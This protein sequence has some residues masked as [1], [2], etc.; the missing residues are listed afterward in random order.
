MGQTAKP[1]RPAA[2]HRGGIR[3]NESF[4]A[5]LECLTDERIIA[6]SKAVWK[7]GPPRRR[8]VSD[9]LRALPRR[10]PPSALGPFRVPFVKP[11]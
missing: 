5:V 11:P 6:Y 9:G 3:W 7:R 10:I 2:W 1:L 8:V 4:F